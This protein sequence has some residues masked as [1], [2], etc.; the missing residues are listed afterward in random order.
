[1][2]LTALAIIFWLAPVQAQDEE[3][4][5]VAELIFIT[6][7]EGQ[8]E[9]LEA[10]IADYH[11]W[12][13]DKEGHFEYNWYAVVTGKRTGEYV[14]RSGNHNW[15]DLDATYDWEEEAAQ[16]F[17]ANVAPLIAKLERRVTEDM[18]DF[19]YWPE[20]FDGYTHITVDN[21]YVKTGQYGKFRSGLE[22]IHK[23]LTEANFGTYYAFISTVSGGHGN[24]ITLVTPRKGWADMADND[25]SFFDIVSEALGGPEEFQSFMSDW[26]STY[27]VGGNQM[28]RLLPEASDYGNDD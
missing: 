16:M 24:E 22:T 3:N 27:K 4:D 15:E 26:G 6:P 21:W 19:D 12:V 10:A 7:V 9:A 14:A 28:V 8:G 23:A 2:A 1:M 18:T 11:H 25:P 20:S 17:E 5:G 13:A